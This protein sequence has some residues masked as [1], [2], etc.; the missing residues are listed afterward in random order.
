MLWCGSDPILIS[1]VGLIALTSTEPGW[2]PIW[3]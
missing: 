1:T 3:T 2:E